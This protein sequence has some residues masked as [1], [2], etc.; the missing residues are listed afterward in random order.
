MPREKNLIRGSEVAYVKDEPTHAPGPARLLE[1]LQIG[2]ASDRI[3]RRPRSGPI[4]PLVE[5]GP[6]QC[7][8]C[9]YKDWLAGR[10]LHLTRERYGCGGASGSLFGVRTRPRKKFVK[11]LADDEGLRARSQPSMEKRRRTRGG[12]RASSSHLLIGPLTASAWAWRVHWNP[13]RPRS[14][15]ALAIRGSVSIARRMIR[16]RSSP[17]SGQ[18]AR[19]S[20]PSGTCAS[21]RRPSAP[22]ISL[23]ASTFPDILIFTVTRTMFEELCDLDERS[24]LYKPFLERLKKARGGRLWLPSSPRRTYA[25]T[26]ELVDDQDMRPGDSGA[27]QGGLASARSM[28]RSVT[29]ASPKASASR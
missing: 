21:P 22:P 4:R 19:S 15:S 26:S 10:M 9:S 27:N 25:V 11:F 1:R 18:G 17:R 13:R 14:P 28:Y 7:V 20:S 16:R 23:C 24:F 5:P 29:S 6:G 12:Y 2:P 3:L 8:F